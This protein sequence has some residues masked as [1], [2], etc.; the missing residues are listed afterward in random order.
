LHPGLSPTEI[1]QTIESTSEQ[2]PAFDGYDASGG[3]V[4][5]A[6]A[7]RSV[8]DTASTVHYEY[9][10][11]NALTGSTQN[12]NVKVTTDSSTIPTGDDVSLSLTLATRVSG[13]TYVVTD[14]PFRVTDPDGQQTTVTTDR[15]G[16]ATSNGGSWPR[17]CEN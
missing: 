9:G 17:L 10:G 3:R 7:V 2:I 14:F 5:V 1:I 8:A 4:D 13:Q 16:T 12:T 6:A 11:F 15:A